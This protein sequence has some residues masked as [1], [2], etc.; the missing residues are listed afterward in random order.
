MNT[1]SELIKELTEKEFL[2]REEIKEILKKRFNTNVNSETFEMDNI[3]EGIIP[4][5][6]D[7]DKQNRTAIVILSQPSEDEEVALCG[8]GIF[9]NKCNV[10]LSF[11]KA[12][13]GNASLQEIALETTKLVEAYNIFSSTNR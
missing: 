5:W 12:L 7:E 10:K 13:V 9:G 6:V 2:T 8:G 3:V 4:S 1:I 11:L